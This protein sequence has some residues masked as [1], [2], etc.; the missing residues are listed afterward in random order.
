MAN[1]IRTG[2]LSLADATVITFLTP[3][4]VGLFSAIFLH[5]P[6]TRKEQLASL[7]ALVGVIFI[8]RPSFLFGHLLYPP[9]SDRS[10]QPII[11]VTPVSTVTG[12][13]QAMAQAAGTGDEIAARRLTGILLALLS[14]LGG[15]GAFIAIKRLGDRAHVLTTTNVFAACCTVISAAAL[16]IA[17]VVG[18]DQPQL[19]FELPQ[20]LRQWVLV[21]AIIV[22]GFLTQ[23][24]VTM[25]IG[26]EGRSNKAPAMVYVGMLWT[27]GFDRFIF[28]QNM[29]WSSFLGCAL[30]I[31]SAVWV[32]LMPK[33]E[34]RPK[35]AD[36]I[37]NDAA[38][39]GPEATLITADRIATK[40][41]D[42]E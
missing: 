15:A 4:M 23:C 28:G 12:D 33:S 34:D 26:S 40:E 11:E 19:R 18:Y 25:G 37:E 31:G 21:F 6:Y 24:L 7:V 42:A 30:I 41:V 35:E 38:V 2:F 8:A 9:S 16:A 27:V 20:D 5:H 13:G 14:A 3:S 10:L 32:L 17:P 1:P 36:D 39:R 22:C 29:Y